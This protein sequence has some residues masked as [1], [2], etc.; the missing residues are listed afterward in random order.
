MPLSAFVVV[1]VAGIA[2][3]PPNV[4]PVLSGLLADRHGLDD[5]QIGYFVSS[6]QLAGLVASATAPYWITRVDVRWLVGACLVVYAVGVFSLGRVMPLAL[7][8]AIQFVLG[9]VLVLVA[10]MT[11]FFRGYD[12]SRVVIVYF[13]L[14]S[15]GVVWFS[16]AAFREG[17]RFAR[18][19]R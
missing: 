14:L 12:Y 13:W 3:L 19:P 2:A 16:R 18:E 7:L 8:Y 15:I 5:A 10:V 11:F 9:G 6:G 1:L 4:M 17:L